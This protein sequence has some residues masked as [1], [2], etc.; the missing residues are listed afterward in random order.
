MSARIELTGQR[1][2]AWTVMRYGG[3]NATRQT[4][5]TCRCE[6]GVERFVVAQALREGLSKSCGCQKSAMI[7]EARTKHGYS[8]TRAYQVWSDMIRRCTNPKAANW[9]SYGGRGIKV[10]D[11]WLSFDV[12][13]SHMGDPPLN[14]SIERIDND[15]NYERLNCKWATVG[16]QNS[17]MRSRK[18]P[19]TGLYFNPNRP[20]ITPEYRAWVSMRSRVSKKNKRVSALYAERN[21]TICPEWSS[22]EQFL[23]DMGPI[24]HPGWTLDRID[25]DRGYAKD[26]CRWADCQVQSQ[27][28]RQNQRNKRAA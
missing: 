17:N 6:C 24:P 8:K 20:H 12:W 1:F 7:A 21:I 14:M 18:D 11:E 15:G 23:A 4:G 9:D 25:N 10:C 22:F 13:H 16:E 19:V 3:M 27:N 2:G 26:N 5:W 28:R